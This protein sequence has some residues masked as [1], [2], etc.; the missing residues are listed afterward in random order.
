MI[1][2]T[3]SEGPQPLPSIA[4][5]SN[6]RRRS[7]TILV[8]LELHPI[9][10]E[11]GAI[12]NGARFQ[13]F[14][15]LTSGLWNLPAARSEFLVQPAEMDGIKAT[16]LSLDEWARG[17]AHLAAQSRGI[18]ELHDN[19]MSAA[20]ISIFGAVCSRAAFTNAAQLRSAASWAPA[21]AP[22]A[23]IGTAAT[24]CSTQRHAAIR[25]SNERPETRR[26]H[27]SAEPDSV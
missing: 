23:T 20:R 18:T 6:S 8:C 4:N 11:S 5:N 1:R 2:C 14:Q 19:Q 16:N 22:P 17:S 13:V 27:R 26:S 15:T 10:Q 21:T 25:T 24:A 3:G 7:C 12:R 9:S